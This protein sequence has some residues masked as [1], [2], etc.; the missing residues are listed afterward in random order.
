MNQ[1]EFV[2]QTLQLAYEIQQIPAPTFQ[3]SRRAAFLYKAFHKL[4]LTEVQIDPSGNVYACLQG[5]S[6]RPVVVSA[7]LDTVHP[8]ETDLTCKIDHDQ[9]IGP[10][11]GDN[12]LGLAGMLSLVKMFQERGNPLPGPLWLV[13]N[14]CEEGLGDLKGARS[15]VERFENSPLAYVILEGIGLGKIFHIGLG[16]IRYRITIKT[17]GGHSWANFGI[18]SAIHEISYLVN[19]LAEIPLP[20]SPRTT[21]NVGIIHGGVSIN[22]I[23]PSAMIEVDIRSESDEKLQ[24]LSEQVQQMAER[25]TRENIQVEIQEIGRRPFGKIKENHPLVSLAKTLQEENGIPVQTGIASTDANIPLSLGYPAVCV[26]LTSGG[27]AH[28]L[29]EYI[30]SEPLEKGLR[31]LF[32]FIDQIWTLS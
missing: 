19:Q 30:E 12:S 3:E 25:L 11:I 7:H 1:S 22:T 8:I 16:V 24:A 15:F 28:T 4:A 29:Y 20:E 18:P 17:P 2:K 10:G 23:A 9:I 27:K 21:L 26:G 32:Q 14:V 31:F 6:G 13:A 5:G